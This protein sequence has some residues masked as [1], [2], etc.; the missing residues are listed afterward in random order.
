MGRAL[1]D[2]KEGVHAQ[3][4]HL[5]DPEDIHRTA[6]RTEAAG[7]LRHCLGKEVVRG[8]IG[9]G[10]PEL[11]ALRDD[12]RRVEDVLGR[13]AREDQLLNA[14]LHGGGIAHSAI[15]VPRPVDSLPGAD[16]RGRESVRVFSISKPEG[17]RLGPAA[18]QAPR[19]ARRDAPCSPGAASATHAVDEQD[20]LHRQ[21]ARRDECRVVLDD[22][23]ITPID[24]VKNYSPSRG[25]ERGEVGREF[26]VLAIDG[27]GEDIGLDRCWIGGC[28]THAHARG[29]HSC[30]SGVSTRL[31]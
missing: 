1:P 27:H 30:M 4:L 13:T 17:H 29:L 31:G 12:L 24:G 15:R 8:A 23:E 3:R 19:G 25:V 26:L 2:P 11:H 18:D 28:R 7:D 6:V 14:A 21:I 22:V 10:A 5:L 9:Q 16:H 20:S